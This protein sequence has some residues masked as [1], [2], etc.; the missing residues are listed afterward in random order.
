MNVC[1]ETTGARHLPHMK[2][3]WDPKQGC[4]KVISLLCWAAVATDCERNSR[5][6]VEKWG[7]LVP[8]GR[9]QPLPLPA[10]RVIMAV[11]CCLLQLQRGMHS[12]IGINRHRGQV[13]LPL[14]LLL[15]L[16]FGQKGKKC[17]MTLCSHLTVLRYRKEFLR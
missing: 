17:R 14:L 3:L 6:P 8:F 4:G 16:C 10:R 5:R 15:I 11:G 2:S 1:Q 7:K 9:M 12:S 13:P